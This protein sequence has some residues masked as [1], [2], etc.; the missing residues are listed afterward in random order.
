MTHV[1]SRRDIARSRRE[2]AP[3][4]LNLNVRGLATSATLA[5]NEQSLALAAPTPSGSDWPTWG[6]GQPPPER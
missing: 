2:Q 3:V 4:H 1:R 6:R 5:A